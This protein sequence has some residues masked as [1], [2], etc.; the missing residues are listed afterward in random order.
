[1]LTGTPWGPVRRTSLR[2]ARARAR[3][4][5]RPARETAVRRTRVVTASV[6]VG[7]SLL[8]AAARACCPRRVG[9]GREPAEACSGRCPTRSARGPNSSPPAACASAFLTCSRLKSRSRPG[10]SSRRRRLASV[11]CG[12]PTPS[13]GTA[14]RP[15][16]GRTSRRVVENPK[17]HVTPRAS[18]RCRGASLRRETEPCR[19][20]G[21]D[22]ARSPRVAAAF[23]RAH[24]PCNRRPT[25]TGAA[26]PVRWSRSRSPARPDREP[27][28]RPRSAEYASP[29]LSAG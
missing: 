1:M 26:A 27:T 2:P 22:R 4:D 19:R 8:A 5:A 13:V 18:R 11:R 3:S 9:V 7:A 15:A 25:C 16:R 12:R 6:L 24:L 28:R 20:R 29:T 23:R 10:R 17:E 14:P 21:C